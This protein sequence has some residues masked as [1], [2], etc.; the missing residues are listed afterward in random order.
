MGTEPAS[1]AETHFATTVRWRRVLLHRRGA[2]LTLLDDEGIDGP[3]RRRADVLGLVD[4]VGGHVIGL[5]SLHRFP[6]ADVTEPAGLGDSGKGGT[7]ERRYSPAVCTGSR[8]QTIT[9]ALDSL[10]R[11]VGPG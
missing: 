2:R 5:P 6:L 11:L 10:T 7:A 9:A 3:R 4:D 8:E 1:H